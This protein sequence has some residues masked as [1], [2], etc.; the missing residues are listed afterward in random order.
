MSTLKRWYFKARAAFDAQ[1]PIGP[2]T[3]RDARVAVRAFYGI[4]ILRGVE[5]WEAPPQG[6]EAWRF[7][8]RDMD[9]D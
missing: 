5:I 4:K 3:L 1:G 9:M 7:R 2:M 6:Q 8:P